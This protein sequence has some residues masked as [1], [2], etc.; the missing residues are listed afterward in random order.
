MVWCEGWSGGAVRMRW[1]PVRWQMSCEGGEVLGGRR[2]VLLRI[3]AGRRFR[4]PLG[5]IQQF[6]FGWS[7]RGVSWFIGDRG[8]AVGGGAW[9][10]G[11]IRWFVRHWGHCQLFTSVV[12]VFVTLFVVGHLEINQI[13][14]EKLMH[15]G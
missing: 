1:L 11:D 3:W 15:S 14:G 2:F 12:D 13:E 6:I 7:W 5:W 9:C 8:G 10:W 4:I